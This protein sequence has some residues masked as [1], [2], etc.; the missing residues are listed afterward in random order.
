MDGMQYKKKPKG[1]QPRKPVKS[2]G[3]FA[4]S[5]ASELKSLGDG[6][7]KGPKTDF[8]ANPDVAKKPKK[9]PSGS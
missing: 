3:E 8:V 4:S 7:R 5:F 6:V 1:K 2:F 9:K